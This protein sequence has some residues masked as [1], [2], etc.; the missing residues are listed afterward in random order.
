MA[1]WNIEQVAAEANDDFLLTHEELMAIFMAHVPTSTAHYELIKSEYEEIIHNIDLDRWNRDAKQQVRDGATSV[2]IDIF[3]PVTLPDKTI[4]VPVSITTNIQV[5]VEEGST[6]TKYVIDHQVKFGGEIITN[7]N[8]TVKV[9]K[10]DITGSLNDWFGQTTDPV[11]NP[12]G[13]RME[14]EF[15]GDPLTGY[16]LT[17]SVTDDPNDPTITSQFYQLWAVASNSPIKAGDRINR[18]K[19]EP[20]GLN[21]FPDGNEGF[22]TVMNPAAADLLRSNAPFTGVAIIDFGSQ[23]VSLVDE[24][25]YQEP[26]I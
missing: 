8:A 1:S 10:D 2:E 24:T 21:V 16:K 15:I 9:I 12:S 17:T 4:E 19:R 22:A 3:I 20:T 7:P 26:L 25:N 23:T 6:E 14:A 13:D 11:T 5:E 18:F